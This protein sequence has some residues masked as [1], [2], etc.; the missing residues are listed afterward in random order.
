M[1]EFTPVFRCHQH[2]D[3][4]VD[5]FVARDVRQAGQ[6][7]VTVPVA[8]DK[9]VKPHGV[10]QDFLQQVLVSVHF[11]ALPAAE[12]SHHHLDARRHGGGVGSTVNLQQVFF[13][14]GSVALV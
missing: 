8:D 7:P 14:T 9:A 6:L 1:P 2:I 11:L 10:F 4:G 3:A 13:A 5:C 12:R